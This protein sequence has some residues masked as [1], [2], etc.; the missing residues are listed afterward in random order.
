MYN[1]L[2]TLDALKEH[3]RTA[4]AQTEREMRATGEALPYLAFVVE[5][6]LISL[7][8]PR[9]IT[10]RCMN[11]GRL[12][13]NLFGGIRALADREHPEAVLIGTDTWH[14]HPTPLGIL[15]SEEWAANWNSGSERLLELGWAVRTEAL[16]M[17]VQDEDYCVIA[18]LPYERHENGTFTMGQMDIKAFRQTEYSGTTKMFGKTTTEEIDQRITDSWKGMPKQ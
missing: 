14:T 18:S 11:S 2:M 3:A 13:E 10:A 15:H 7:P 4:L 17:T 9:E 1:F 8:I 12:K 16:T 5:G 6:K